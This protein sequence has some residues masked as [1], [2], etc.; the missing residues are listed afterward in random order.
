MSFEFKEIAGYE[1]EKRELI[2]LCEVIK[3][4]DKYARRG[5]R[6]PKGI[7]FYGA[8]G[9]GKTMFAREMANACGLR[10]VRIDA[11]NITNGHALCKR[12]RRA[13]SLRSK[14]KGPAM[15]LFDEIDKVLPNRREEY[16]TDQSKMILTQLLTLIDGLDCGGNFVFVATCNDYMALPRAL[17]RPGRIDKKICLGMP[18]LYVLSVA[19]ENPVHNFAISAVGSSNLHSVSEIYLSRIAVRESEMFPQRQHT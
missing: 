4:R 18:T 15:I 9:M 16:C 11:G 3:D 12:I 19:Q 17:V 5:G 13:F 6:V 2:R 7:I 8:T 10:I 14:R 1:R